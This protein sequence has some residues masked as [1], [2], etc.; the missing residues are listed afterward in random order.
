MLAP[1]H[2]LNG[3]HFEGFGDPGMQKTLSE[4]QSPDLLNFCI[5]M[6]I[7]SRSQ[8]LLPDEDSI[9]LCFTSVSRSIITMLRRF[10][11]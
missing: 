10:L 7:L 9:L 1:G 8:H 4:K 11:V 2:L 5:P 6:S 3:G